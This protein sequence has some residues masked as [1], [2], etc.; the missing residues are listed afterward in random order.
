MALTGSGSGGAGGGATTGAPY[1]AGTQITIRNDSGTNNLTVYTVPAGKKFIGIIQRDETRLFSVNDQ[2]APKYLN[3]NY[4]SN[5]AFYSIPAT[6]I[7]LVAGSVV[8]KYGAHSD[9][10]KILGVESDA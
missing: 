2:R 1:Q 8:K 9:Y 10:I 3:G 7:H 5:G 4:Q 6:K